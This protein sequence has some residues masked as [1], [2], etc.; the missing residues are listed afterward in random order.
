MSTL[1][2]GAS[3]AHP[4]DSPQTGHAAHAALSAQPARWGHRAQEGRM[5]GR[6]DRGWRA[7]ADLGCLAAGVAAMFFVAVRFDVPGRLF[8]SS[9][10]A[11]R[12]Q[13]PMLLLG[14]IALALVLF[15]YRRW[16]EVTANRD[17]AAR[18]A[19]RDALTGLPDR[20]VFQER[21]QAAL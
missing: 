15:G 19:H 21:L 6:N 4:A 16:R 13:Q 5:T 12:L 3:C 9:A 18:W 17:D 11:T 20:V 1:S 2:H 8:S 14:L 10:D 7:A